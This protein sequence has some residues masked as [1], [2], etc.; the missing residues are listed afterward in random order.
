MLSAQVISVMPASTSG[1][2]AAEESKR[3]P[4]TSVVHP[5]PICEPCIED[6]AVLHE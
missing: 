5:L 4:P 2:P 6:G 1:P 3:E